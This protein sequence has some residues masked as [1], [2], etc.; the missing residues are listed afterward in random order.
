MEEINEVGRFER[1]IQQQRE[2]YYVSVPISWIKTKGLRRYDEVIVQL[3]NDGSL[4]ISKRAE[5]DFH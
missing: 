5:H 4:R 3:M 1:R 2:S